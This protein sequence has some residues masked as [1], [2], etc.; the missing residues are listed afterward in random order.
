[1]IDGEPP[2]TT[3]D[4]DGCLTSSTLDARERVASGSRGACLREP[5]PF[6]ATDRKALTAAPGQ[7]QDYA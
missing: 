6:L 3:K 7:R 5:E 1:M 2:S 4:R